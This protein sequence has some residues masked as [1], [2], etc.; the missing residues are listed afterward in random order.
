MSYRFTRRPGHFTRLRMITGVIRW[1]PAIGSPMGDIADAFVLV[2]KR[3]SRAQEAQGSGSHSS[4]EE[5]LSVVDDCTVTFSDGSDA[6]GRAVNFLIRGLRNNPEI[7]EG[8]FPGD[9]YYQVE[10]Q[11]KARWSSGWQRASAHRFVDP[12][13]QRVTLTNNNPIGHMEFSVRT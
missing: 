6:E 3:K 10:P 12:S 8:G 2:V 9:G 11:L 7:Y 4:T 1:N 5:T 13:F